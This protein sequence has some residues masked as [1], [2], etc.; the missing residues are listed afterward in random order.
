[1][2]SSVGGT[3]TTAVE[4]LP[5]PLLS[6]YCH[7]HKLR[8]P[9]PAG[10]PWGTAQEVL[11]HTDHAWVHSGTG[12][13]CSPGKPLHYD[14]GAC[15]CASPLSCTSVGLEQGTPGCGSAVAGTL[16]FFFIIERLLKQC[17][18]QLLQSIFF[19]GPPPMNE[20]GLLPLKLPLQRP[21]EKCIGTPFS[22]HKEET[23]MKS[24]GS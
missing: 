5:L 20:T 9:L 6:S 24:Q 3:A 1:M 2:P 19:K 14:C 15:C 17:Q 22:R 16:C 4:P 11:L 8:K 13:C 7:C 18:H 21:R 23:K 10:K 12:H